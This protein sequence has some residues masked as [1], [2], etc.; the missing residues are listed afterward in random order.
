MADPEAPGPPPAPGGPLRF[1]WF[2]GILTAPRPAD[3][4]PIRREVRRI[5]ALGFGEP[6]LQVEG[7]RFTLMMPERCLPGERLAPGAREEFAGALQVVLDL[8]PGQGEVESTLRCTEVLADSTRETLFA[9]A[10]RELRAVGRL[11]PV[12]A[13]DLA[14]DPLPPSRMPVTNLS[15]RG[16]L[17]LM[18]LLV[19]G[20]GLLAWRTGW[21]D[22]IFSADFDAL[23]AETGPFQDML[24][25]EVAGSWGDY[26]VT[27]SR[28]AGYPATREEVDRRLAASVSAADRAAVNAVADGGTIYLRVQDA[29]G[30]VLHVKEANL[31]PLISEEKGQ[32]KERLP[33]AIAARAIRIALDA[34]KKD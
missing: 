26:E 15:R 23:A 1:V 33:G 32:V 22:R 30:R 3:L 6:E 10:G 13:Q 24:A 20:F 28:G 5:G 21:I 34:G 8:L 29:E 27:V 12:Q 14:H 4:A 11:R 2:D 17:G 7:A 19:A 25:V 18:A 9:A 31:R 16:L